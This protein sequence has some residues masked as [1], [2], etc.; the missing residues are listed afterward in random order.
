M[1][2]SSFALTSLSDYADPNFREPQPLDRALAQHKAKL[3]R[4]NRVLLIDQVQ[5]DADTVQ[6]T[7]LDDAYEQFGLA[8]LAHPHST[9]SQAFEYLWSQVFQGAAFAET[10]QYTLDAFCSTSSEYSA[11][12]TALSLPGTSTT[13]AAGSHAARGTSHESS[14]AERVGDLRSEYSRGER[15]PDRAATSHSMST[16]GDLYIDGTAASPVDEAVS[17]AVYFPWTPHHIRP[18]RELQGTDPEPDG[19]EPFPEF[20]SSV[21]VEAQAD[22][23]ATELTARPANNR[24]DVAGTVSPFRGAEHSSD[25]D[26]S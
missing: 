1:A 16:R 23:G 14:A 6:D 13:T 3:L 5:T 15:R 7:G 26:R 25:E 19:L 11:L 2:N 24:L 21:M 8:A 10:F 17:G 4:I 12:E 18:T 22:V 9:A 20:D